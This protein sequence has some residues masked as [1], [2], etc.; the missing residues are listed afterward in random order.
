MK[1][2]LLLLFPILFM[3][4]GD[5]FV[6]LVTFGSENVRT[7]YI[8]VSPFALVKKCIEGEMTYFRSTPDGHCKQYIAEFTKHNN[9]DY[10]YEEMC[11]KARSTADKHNID[12]LFTDITHTVEGKVF[13]E[14]K[15]LDEISLDSTWHIFFVNN[16]YELIM[17][18]PLDKES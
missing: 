9:V 12:S 1:K 3:S 8:D 6:E 7:E 10:S 2:L 11:A 18:Y 5:K 17:Y 4:C 13:V 16:R 15:Y 14:E